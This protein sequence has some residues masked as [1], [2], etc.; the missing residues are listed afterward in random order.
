MKAPRSELKAFI[1]ERLRRTLVYSARHCE[2]YRERFKQAGLTR[3]ADLIIDNLRYIPALTRQDIQKAFEALT[4]DGISRATWRE[5][6]SGGS[7]GKP[8]VLLQDSHY[9]KEGVAISFVSDIMQGWNYGNRV[10]YLWGSQRDTKAG[11]HLISRCREYLSNRQLYDSF[12]MA[13]AK[14]RAFHRKLT[15]FHPNNL[16]AYANSAF[17][18]SSFLLKEGIKPSYPTVSIISSAET[19]TEPMR[20]T[21]EQCFGVPV[22]N[23]YGSREVGTIAS[24]CSRRGGLHI[25]LDKH[26]EVIDSESGDPLNERAGQILVTLFTNRAMPLI[27]YEVGDAGVLTDVPCGC[28]LNTPLLKQIIGRSSDFITSPS[29]R[30]IHGEYFTHVFYGHRS[31]R[32]FLFVQETRTRFIV[33][34][35]CEDQLDPRAKAKFL[36]E[37][38]SVLGAEAEVSMEIVDHIP[39][40]P[41]GKFR[42]TISR[43][44]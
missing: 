37:I 42:F 13:P 3:E 33:K 35:V 43:V 9:R 27:R 5:N 2:F 36:H 25:H 38:Q 11:E 14:M 30:L 18:Y 41:S 8:V 31:V 29:G 21:I 4:A 1:A 17:L 32:Q 15:E 7:T 22:Y 28:G 10:A 44:Q 40:L 26:V 23:R 20:S 16:V 39:P 24:E 12:D 6:S 34:I 19:L